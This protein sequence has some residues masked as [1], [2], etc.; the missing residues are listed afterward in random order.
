[1]T[2]QTLEQEFNKVA[3]RIRLEKRFESIMAGLIP[4]EQL[5]EW[6]P[7]FL[8]QTATRYLGTKVAKVVEVQAQKFLFFATENQRENIYNYLD[9]CAKRIEDLGVEGFL[10]EKWDVTS[11]VLFD[12]ALQSASETSDS[13][14]YRILSDLLFSM[15]SSENRDGLLVSCSKEAALAISKLSQDHLKDLALYT[16]VSTVISAEIQDYKAPQKADTVAFRID[17]LVNS[18]GITS[19]SRQDRERMVEVGVLKHS[20]HFRKPVDKMLTAIMV[21]KELTRKSTWSRN[22]F[23]IKPNNSTSV[24]S[25]RFWSSSKGEVLKDDLF[26]DYSLTTVGKL[27]GFL[28][29]RE[30]SNYDGPFYDLEE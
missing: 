16:V 15:F 5:G 27:I 4:F 12:V 23:G 24:A 17:S 21:D 19:L 2:E 13:E 30:L 8:G 28:V 18:L 26:I 7:I 1:M 22:I 14:K 9:V 6:V 20:I 10:D 11:E 3:V 25:K 29:L